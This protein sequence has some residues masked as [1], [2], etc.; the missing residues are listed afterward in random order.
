MKKKKK[1]VKE[2]IPISKGC[3]KH[4]KC[5]ELFLFSCFRIAYVSSCFLG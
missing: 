5:L 4:E 1:G 2:N 3:F